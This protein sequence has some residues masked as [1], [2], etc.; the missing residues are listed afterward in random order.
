[1]VTLILTE[2]TRDSIFLKILGELCGIV[3]IE[4]NA[5]HIIC[6]KIVDSLF[7]GYISLYG[8]TEDK[9]MI[10]PCGGIGTV[11]LILINIL[12]SFHSGFKKPLLIN[13]IYFEKDKDIPEIVYEK[14]EINNCKIYVIVDGDCVDNLDKELSILCQ[15]LNIRYLRDK[16]RIPLEI[17]SLDLFKLEFQHN[18]NTYALKL[19]CYRETLENIVLNILRDCNT[20]NTEKFLQIVN[21][22]LKANV[23]I[24]NAVKGSLFLFGSSLNEQF[25]A[26]I[27]EVR[28]CGKDSYV[29]KDLISIF[30]YE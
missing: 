30:H 29:C 12:Y 22:F 24:S 14:I 23:K 1:M 4:R 7:I 6:R 5:K 10:V 3:R 18:N 2:G 25:N 16:K 20:E 11:K 27:S 19:L 15:K 17:L 28:L 8:T 21:E 26:I 13:Y 9:L